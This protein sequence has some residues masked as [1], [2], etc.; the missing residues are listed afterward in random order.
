MARIDK[1]DPIIGSHRVDVAANFPDADIGKLFGW[2]LDSAGKA[3]VGA[4]VSGVIGVWVINDQ[5]GRVGPLRDVPRIDIMRQGC[6]TDFGPT[7]GTPGVTFG[8]AS[9]KYYCTPAGAIVTAATAGNYYVGTTV[10][11]D[12]L[13]V[14]F[15]PIPVV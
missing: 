15:H 12:R 3:V 8:T 5:P 9:T 4:G 10:E 7:A 13:E 2:G 11:P 6:V 14:N 1:N